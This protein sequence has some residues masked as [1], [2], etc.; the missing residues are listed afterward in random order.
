ME[1]GVSLWVA[2]DQD[3][4]LW[5]FSEKPT[6]SKIDGGS[7]ICDGN[8]M[9]L[10]KNLEDGQQFSSLTWESE[11]ISVRL[12]KYL[13]ITTLSTRLSNELVDSQFRSLTDVAGTYLDTGPSSVFYDCRADG[14]VDDIF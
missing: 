3:G 6:R 7:W 10:P 14:G 12:S 4:S 5:L 2:K 13:N 1:R 8:F 9:M 11:P